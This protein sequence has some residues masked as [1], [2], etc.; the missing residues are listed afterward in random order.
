MKLQVVGLIS[1]CELYH[2]RCQAKGVGDVES[3][4]RKQVGSLVRNAS[5]T[6]SLISLCQQEYTYEWGEIFSHNIYFTLKCVYHLLTIKGDLLLWDGTSFGPKSAPEQNFGPKM[7]MGPHHDIH[8]EG[9]HHPP[10]EYKWKT[11]VSKDQYLRI[12][13]ESCTSLVNWFT[14]Y[15]SIYF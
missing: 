13:N 9:H 6:W 3:M 4:P 15:R 1:L 12:S 10:K 11:N 5:C 14:L 2:S 7:V 8:H